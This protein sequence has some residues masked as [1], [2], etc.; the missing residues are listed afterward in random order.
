MNAYKTTIKFVS[1]SIPTSFSY[2]QSNANCMHAFVCVRERECVSVCVYVL[3]VSVYVYVMDQNE[4]ACDSN[5]PCV[6]P[7]LLIRR[8]DPPLGALDSII[9]FALRTTTC[10]VDPSS[11]HPPKWTDFVGHF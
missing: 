2:F 8:S 4:C 10:S 6:K 7:P 5:T 9:R 3:Y 1:E 11:Y